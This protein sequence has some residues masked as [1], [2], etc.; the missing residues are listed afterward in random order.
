MA[1]RPSERPLRVA[2]FENPRDAARALDRLHES[3]FGAKDLTIFCSDD[4]CRRHFGLGDV[5]PPSGARTPS[6][7][8]R[9]GILGSLLAG[10]GVVAGIVTAGGTLVFAA[11]AL[12]PVLIGGGVA[13]SF[14]GAMA[15]RGV[16]KEAADYFDQAVEAGDVLVA[17]QTSDDDPDRLALAGRTLAAAGARPIPLREG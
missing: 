4:A 12:V 6:W 17:V 7:A 16:E 5:E 14:A 10:I 1:S 3:G 15:S 2:V 9:G 8:R 11:G 13:G